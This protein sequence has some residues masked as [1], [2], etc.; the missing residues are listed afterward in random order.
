MNKI[1]MKF[2]WKYKTFLSQQMHL[3]A[4]SA[5]DNRFSIKIRLYSF[6]DNNNTHFI[7]LIQHG[8][9]KKKLWLKKKKWP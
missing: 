5:D 2:E 9:K 3:Q 8:S 4:P 6:F 1:T 7:K